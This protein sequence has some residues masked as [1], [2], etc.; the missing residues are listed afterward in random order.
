MC[1]KKYIIILIILTVYL[2]I[3]PET[4]ESRDNIPKHVKIT[5]FQ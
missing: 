5:S 1:A 3:I 4:Y 2:Y